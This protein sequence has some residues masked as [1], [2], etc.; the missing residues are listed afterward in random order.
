[1]SALIEEHEQA[2][3]AH[4]ALKVIPDDAVETIEALCEY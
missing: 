1:L 4:I 2:A 3:I